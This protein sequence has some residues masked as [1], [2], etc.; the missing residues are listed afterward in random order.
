MSGLLP[1]LSSVPTQQQQ[2]LLLPNVIPSGNLPVVKVTTVKANAHAA[3]QHL[4]PMRSVRGGIVKS[5]LG[6]DDGGCGY[7]GQ[8]VVGNSAQYLGK[9]AAAQQ[10][11]EWTCY[12]RGVRPEIDVSA[13]VARVEF[14]LHESFAVPVRAV[15]APPFQVTERGW[16]EFEVGIKVF[17]A[18]PQEEPVHFVHQLRLYEDIAAPPNAKRLLT[19]ERVEE[20]LFSPNVSDEFRAILEECSRATFAPKKRRLGGLGIA[21][22]ENCQCR[23]PVL[24][25]SHCLS[26]SY[27]AHR[28]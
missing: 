2:Q 15:T 25:F 22:D 17:F 3:Q 8:V 23:Q 5:P 6:S 9:K 16:G 18:D 27:S 11:H 28:S 20:I 7:Y 24:C 19:V 13:W 4:A 14:R 26:L 12:V 21:I 10:T 1:A